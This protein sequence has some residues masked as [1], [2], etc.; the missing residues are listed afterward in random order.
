[1]GN[2]GLPLLS[3]CRRSACV[4][5]CGRPACRAA[6][7]DRSGRATIGKFTLGRSL[8]AILILMMAGA[9]LRAADSP[10]KAALDW[11]AADAVACVEIPHPDR[12]IDRL[13]DPLIL[14]YASS[15]PQYRAAV[16]S[17]NFRELSGVVKLLA[18]QLDTTW[19]QGLKDLTGG[20]L[21]LTVEAEKAAEPRVFLIVSP[22][23]E[24]LLDRA[25]QAILKL[26]RADATNKGKPDPVKTSDCKGVTIYSTGDGEAP[27]YA[28]L[29]GRLVVSNSAKN[30][31]KLIDRALAV[32]TGN[33]Q[34]GNAKFAE[35]AEW[36]ALKARGGDDD[37]VVALARLDRLRKLDPARFT[38]SDKPD[39]GVTLLFR[40][41]YELLKRAPW[42]SFAARWSD[43]E[44]AGTLELPL[45][46]QGHLAIVKGYVPDGG[47]GAAGLI[48]PPGTIASLSLWRDWATLWE[49]RADLFS[50]EVAQNL[51]QLDTAT[52]QFFGGREF[53]ADVL[54]SLG[55]HWRLVIAQQDYGNLKPAPDVKLP[56]FAIVAEIAEPEGDFGQKLK[57]AYQTIVGLSNIDA[58]QQKA[59]PL[60]LGSE[61]V[62]GV[63][64]ATARY[65]LPPGAAADQMT[66]QRRYNFSPSAAQVGKF[67]I[68][69]SSR[70]LA[71]SLIKEL[72]GKNAAAARAAAARS[73]FAVEAEGRELARILDLNRD[74]LAM[75][76]MLER[77]ETKEKAQA[78]VDQ[79]L[80]FV[81]YLGR[82]RL[83]I[84]DAKNASR[85]ELK[86]QLSGGK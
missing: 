9:P 86:F 4:G 19:D 70:D 81:R 40:S 30:L 62:E 43:Q 78:Q 75:Q 28:I 56:G 57:T 65:V 23:D 35:C 8:R 59:A 64:L 72:K 52:G 63:T 16:Q 45:P 80:A 24:A 66:P 13:T 12:L 25:H 53:G 74:R 42:L 44:L 31:S 49:S 58:T 71:R 27:G 5:L 41:W 10:T 46:P 21:V 60:E 48:Q 36:K 26:A 73:T 3:W 6:A 22:R 68:L 11:I 69:S 18:A 84:E 37:S 50:A 14:N 7:S 61:E 38:P 2:A 82:G 39:T 15:L 54:G 32:E 67:F 33:R 79:L 55:P 85:L 76:T 51:A 1:M 20:G 17:K 77:G 83:S 34:G 29:R 47:E